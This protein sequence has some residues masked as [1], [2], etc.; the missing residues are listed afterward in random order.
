MNFDI[1]NA[2][3]APSGGRLQ[4][5]LDAGRRDLAALQR[6]PGFDPCIDAAKER[7]YLLKSRLLE[8]VGRNR[9]GSLIRAVAINHNFHIAGVIGQNRIAVGRMRRESAGNDAVERTNV[10]RPHIENRQVLAVVDQLTK[11]VDRDA[12]H[13]QLAD[14]QLPPDPFCQD[15]QSE[16]CENGDDAK[17]A[18]LGKR[19]KDA[20]DGIL[21]D[22]AE[23]DRGAHVQ[24]FACAIEQDEERHNHSA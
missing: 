18:K 13:A 7:S 19:G 20:C 6:L 24:K 17:F 2:E 14:E 9:G 22:A 1:T 16:R 10:S 12:V 21:E 11:L 8:M 4:H 23:G 3:T 15:V 5:G